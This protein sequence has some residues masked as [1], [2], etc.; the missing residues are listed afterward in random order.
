GLILRGRRASGSRSPAAWWSASS[1]GRSRCSTTTARWPSCASRSPGLP[2]SRGRSG[3][4]QPDATGVGAAAGR[5]GRGG[6]PGR[7]RFARRR[8]LAGAALTGQ[9][10]LAQLAPLFLGRPAPDARFLV[11]GEGELEARALHVALGAHRFG[12]GDLLE[13][14][15]GR[16][17]R[18]EQ[19]RVRVA[20]GRARSPVGKVPLDGA[21][22]RKRQRRLRAA[23]EAD[24]EG[25]RY[26]K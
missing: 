2:H 24:K 20:T 18:E 3:P 16:P 25:K 13:R 15:P 17:D 21:G 19:V 1:M 8:A 6:D 10:G 14:D 26:G 7:V 23:A 9:P 22:P 11:G 12:G 5:D 4:G